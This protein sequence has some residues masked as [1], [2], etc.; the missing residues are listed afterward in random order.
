MN[1]KWVSFSPHILSRSSTTKIYITMLVL[2]CPTV[3]S[4]VVTLNYNPLLLIVTSMLSCYITDII[5]KLAVEKSYDFSD[6]SALFIGFIIGIS[7]PSGAGWFVPIL[8]SCFSIVFIRNIAGGIGKNFVSEIAV[9]V[10]ISYLIF[11]SEFSM[12]VMNGGEVVAQSGLDRVM[13][14]EITKINIESLFFGGYAGSIADSSIFWLFIGCFAL[15]ILKIIDLRI[16]VLTLLSVFGFSALFFD[17]TTAVNLMFTGG[18]ILAS[19]FVATDYAVVPKNKL[20]KCVYAVLIGLFTALIWK[21]GTYT[22]AVYYA[23]VIVGLISS[24]FSGITKTLK[25]SV[26]R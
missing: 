16:P 23:I 14:G 4:A 6:V 7:M 9:A 11:D 1:N 15:A 20:A 24:V 19:F 26:V 25:V 10:L 22:M 12:Y 8:G 3:A 21:Y 13:S 17:V 18:V 2:L 5:F